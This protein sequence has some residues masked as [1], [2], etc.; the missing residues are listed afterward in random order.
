LITQLYRYALS[1][2]PHASERRIALEFLQVARGSGKF[3]SES[4]EDLLWAVLQSP[5][6]QFIH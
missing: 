4:V 2:D 1:R 6:F 5:E 3:S